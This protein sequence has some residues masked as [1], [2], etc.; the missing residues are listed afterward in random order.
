MADLYSQKLLIQSALTFFVAGLVL[1]GLAQDASTL[2]F[3]RVFRSRDHRAEQE[4]DAAL[5]A[6][7]RAALRQSEGTPST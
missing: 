6:A 4:R 5:A 1:S 7:I 2:I 3:A